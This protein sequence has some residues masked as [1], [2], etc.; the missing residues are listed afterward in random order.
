MIFQEEQYFNYKDNSGLVA[1]NIG[2]HSSKWLS[3]DEAVLSTDKNKIVA[4]MKENHFDVIP[5]WNKKKDRYISYVSTLK[6]GVFNGEINSH[7]IENE[8]SI[9]YLTYIED[10]IRMMVENERNF[11]FLNN[12][13][14]V[15][16]LLTISDLNSKYFY[17]W[18]YSKIINLEKGIAGFLLSCRNEKEILELSETLA[19]T[20]SDEGKGFKDSLKRYKDD[21]EKNQNISFIEYLYFS[22]LIKLIKEFKLYDKL[23][24]KNLSKFEYQTSRVKDI[25]NTIAHP[26][27][28]LVCDKMS[29]EDLWIGMRKMEELLLKLS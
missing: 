3:F 8:S 6:W 26:V 11:Y 22:Q 20:S 25:R 2:V 4:A 14:E 29:L 9:Y 1:A 19:Q 13:S 17:R 21:L 23:G 16:G 10:V 28:S 12:Y 7:K 15:I 18:L 24:Y 5:L 27:R